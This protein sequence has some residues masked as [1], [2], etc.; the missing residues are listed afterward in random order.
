M[1]LGGKRRGRNW[2]FVSS[3]QSL[4]RPQSGTVLV[5]LVVG[6]QDQSNSATALN[7][8]SL[9][10]WNRLIREELFTLAVSLAVV[11]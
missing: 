5:V 8:F 7:K 11:S 2:L 10:A 4:N 3:F 9:G 1:R 6:G